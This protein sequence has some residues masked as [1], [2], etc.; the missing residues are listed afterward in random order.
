MDHDVKN[1][2]SNVKDIINMLSAAS[3]GSRVLVMTNQKPPSPAG[4]LFAQ[5]LLKATSSASLEDTT[6][7]GSTQEGDSDHETV[8]D[9]KTEPDGSLYTGD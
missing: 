7:V 8:T 6:L 3:S 4:R 5:D 1:Q 2:T 9:E